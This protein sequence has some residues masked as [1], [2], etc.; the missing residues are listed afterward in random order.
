MGFSVR[1]APGVRVRASSRGI[2]TSFGTRAARIHVGA[3]R[4]GFSTGAGPFTYYTNVGGSKRKRRSVARSRAASTPRTASA[5]TAA[6]RSTTRTTITLAQANKQQEASRLRDAFEAIT[7]IHQETFAPAQKPLAPPAALVDAGAIRR[8]CTAAAL[9]GVGLFDRAGRTAAKEKALAE[10]E[11]RIQKEVQARR[12]Q[13]VEQ[14]GELNQLWVRLLANDPE[15]V[16]DRLAT[17]FEDNE[18]AAAP[19][20]VSEAEATIVVLL[21]GEDVVPTRR[22]TT[23]AAGNL[24]L[25]RMAKKD[26]DAF[27]TRLAAGYA[28]VTIKEAFAVAPALESVRVVAVRRVKKNAYGAKLAE[29]LLAAQVRLSALAGV[30]W[31]SQDAPTLLR[32]VAD[33]LLIHEKGVAKTLTPLD[34]STEPELEKV[35][36]SIDFDELDR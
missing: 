17:A 11:L 25:K 1:I 9:K 6:S 19:L 34:L 35:V 30:Q 24:S 14:Q 10:A 36:D 21:P 27:Y 31:T 15:T 3:G 20:G 28:L 18:A 12:E 2:R 5:S 16:L 23:T 33:E 4:T 8:E 7:T 32:D 26:R 22:P 29:V 13:A